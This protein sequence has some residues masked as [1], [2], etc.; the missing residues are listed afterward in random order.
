VSRDD[1][2][3]R[4]ELQA[5]RQRHDELGRALYEKRRPNGEPWAELDE[6]TR[7]QW[8]LIAVDRQGAVDT[9]QPV[10]LCARMVCQHPESAHTRGPSACTQCGCTAWVSPELP[11]DPAVQPNVHEL[12]PDATEQVDPELRAGLR[13]LFGQMEAL[14]DSQD[15]AQPHC[16]LVTDPQTSRSWVIGSFHNRLHA[17]VAIPL[18]EARYRKADPDFVFTYTPMIF[19]KPPWETE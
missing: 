9:R 2:A 15:A 10:P 3:E 7:L 8:T 19:E 6:D 4:Y 18:I 12:R 1:E 5:E 13:K 16:L 11:N 17:R 14:S